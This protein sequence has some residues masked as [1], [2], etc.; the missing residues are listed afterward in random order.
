MS[1]GVAALG[2]AAA[3]IGTAVVAGLGY[4]VSQADA[5]K[6]ALNDFCAATGTATEDAEAYKQV[7]ENIYNG[8]YGEGFED[9][10]AAMAEIKQQAGDLGSG[11]AG[12]NDN[13]RLNPA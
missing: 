4:T 11:R 13:Q 9:I 3:A 12:K 5:A 10:A 8:N 6:G 2:T 1:T 7:M